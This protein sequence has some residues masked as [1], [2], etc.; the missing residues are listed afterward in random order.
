VKKAKPAASK[1]QAALKLKSQ[2]PSSKPQ[3]RPVIVFA[4]QPEALSLVHRA[5]EDYRR[6]YERGDGEALLLAIDLY[7][8]SFTA[9]KWMADGFFDAI[10]RWLDCRAATLDKAFNVQQ[11]GKHLDQ[12]RERERLRP[13][14]MLEL[15]RL[16]QRNGAPM[17]MR[18][19]ARVGVD[20][21]KSGSYVRNV[22]YEEAS[23]PWRKLLRHFRVERRS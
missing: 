8:E 15:V 5:L 6:R 21:G 7:L 2:P 11:I 19:F 12:Q 4:R 13:I 9:P 1:P 14:I 23:A 20:I 10:S 16:R 3:S 18:T 17:D 22:Y